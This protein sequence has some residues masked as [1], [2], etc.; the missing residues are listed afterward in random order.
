MRC[1]AANVLREGASS[2]QG[3]DQCQLP[4]APRIGLDAPRHPETKPLVKH[5][6]LEV[7]GLERDLVAASGS[8]FALDHRHEPGAIALATQMRWHKQVANVAGAAP[9]PAKEAT[10]GR[11]VC[12]VQEHRQ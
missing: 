6:S 3:F 12:L 4:M 10:E 7:V 11:P 2:A 9:G 5:R 1:H 8:G